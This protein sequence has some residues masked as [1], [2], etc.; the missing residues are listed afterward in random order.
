MKR[1]PLK[2]HSVRVATC[3]TPGCVHVM[4]LDASGDGF[5]E[6]VLSA[7]DAWSYANDLLRAA[8]SPASREHQAGDTDDPS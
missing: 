3:D 4:L 6:A 2:A 8:G 1:A 5:A 7:E